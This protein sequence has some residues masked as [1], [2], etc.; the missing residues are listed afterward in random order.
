MPWPVATSG[1]RSGYSARVTESVVLIVSQG[2]VSSLKLTQCAVSVT[3]Q[4]N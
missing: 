4:S 3:S 1:I 2:R